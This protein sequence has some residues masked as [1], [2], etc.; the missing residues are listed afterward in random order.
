MAKIKVLCNGDVYEYDDKWKTWIYKSKIMG[1]LKEY[2]GKDVCVI[3]DL[4]DTFMYC[5]WNDREKN[6]QILMAEELLKYFD[7]IDD[8]WKKYVKTIPTEIIL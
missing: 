1:V 8:N 7:T 5:L 3:T 2:T 4:G 6:H